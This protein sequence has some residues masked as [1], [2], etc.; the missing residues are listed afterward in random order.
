LSGRAIAT[1]LAILLLSLTACKG[2][3]STESAPPSETNE[4][5]KEL[6]V[7]MREPG[8]IDPA[9]LN[10]SNDFQVAV[11]IYEGLYRFDP[12]HERAEA[13]LVELHKTDDEHRVWQFQLK[14]SARY[15]DGTPIRAADFLYAWQRILTPAT[16]SPGADALFILRH[17]RKIAAGEELKLAVTV[18][19]ENDLRIELESPQPYLP[20]ILAS[21]RFAPLPERSIKKPEDDFS[22][23]G[24]DL[25]SGPYHVVEWKPRESMTLEPNPHYEFPAGKEPFGRITLRFSDSE[26]TAL[27]WWDAGQVDVVQGLVPFQKLL[28]LRGKYPGALVSRPMHSVFYLFFNQQSKAFADVGVRRALFG[29]IDREGL[30]DDVLS[31]GQLPALA[32]V[33][34]TYAAATGFDAEPCKTLP[35]EEAREKL[36]EGRDALAGT[37]MICNASETLR[38]IMEYVQQGFSKELDLFLAIR[39]LEWGSFLA[40]LKQGDFQLAR[41]SLSGGPDP[42]DFFENFTTK[43]SNNFGGFASKEYDQLVSAIA[44]TGDMEERADVMRRA[45]IILCRELPAIPVYFSTQ[46]Y[47]VREHLRGKFRPTAQGYVLFQSLR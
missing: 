32:F 15:G 33:P 14:P 36:E 17:G 30:T 29:A 35:R 31:G 23:V 6:A 2:E 43:S 7:A 38:T 4:A 25:A 28:F 13:A 46:V 44:T 34:P 21:P 9:F 45:H 37:E 27:T 47:L 12:V 18:V 5:P 42:L 39:M 20:E 19:G 11:N 22:I 41:M 24:L 8:S 26:E 10:G 40:S 16:A 3:K 1:L